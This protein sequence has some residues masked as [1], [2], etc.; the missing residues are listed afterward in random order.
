MNITAKMII[1]L[2]ILTTLI[3]GIL[4]AWDGFTAPK[5]QQHRQEALEAAIAEVLPSYSTY[6]KISTGSFP[7]YVGKRE[8]GSV[9]GVAFEAS[10]SGFQGVI[11][12]M[13][14]LTP[15]FRKI[16]GLKVLE[17]VETPGLG[18]RIAGDPM[19]KSNP[20]WFT[21]QFKGVD[22][23][24]KIDAVKN[25]KPSNPHEIQAITGATISSKSVVKILNTLIQKAKT[26]YQQ[27]TGQV[28]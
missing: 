2:T 16:T 8:D 1:V 7:L 28:S 14:G 21:D 9:V 18:A 15:D 5:I 11:S 13:V 23:L 4:A 26:A 22:P 17:Q 25:Q 6:E 27:S 10:G 19:N 20:G 24:P 3:G 12:M